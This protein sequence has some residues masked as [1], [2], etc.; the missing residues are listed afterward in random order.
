MFCAVLGCE[1]SDLIVAEPETVPAPD[2]AL[3]EPDRATGTVTD[4][5]PVRRIAPRPRTGRSLP[6]R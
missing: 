6:P 4:V 1:I 5:A 3:A 2:P